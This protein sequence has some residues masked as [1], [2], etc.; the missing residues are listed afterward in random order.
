MKRL[1]SVVL[2]V[3]LW[4]CSNIAVSET[5]DIIMA[6]PV[7]HSASAML[8]T[9]KDVSFDFSTTST[10]SYIMTTRC[11]LQKKIGNYWIGVKELEAPDVI[12]TN[13]AFYGAFMDYA[14]DIGTG[15]YRVGYTAKADG[16]SIT[17]YT[18]SR[19]FD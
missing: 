1:I 9:R 4:A 12:A 14:A 17:R 10:V 5:A 19:T 18:N 3:I 2:I 16:H 8:S 13:T 6:D 7:F 11:W 15:T